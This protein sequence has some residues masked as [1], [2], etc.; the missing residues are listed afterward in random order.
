[1]FQQA[2]IG[3]GSKPAAFFAV[4]NAGTR[5]QQQR[6]RKP[7]VVLLQTILA[8]ARTCREVAKHAEV[9][10]RPCLV[11]FFIDQA[12]A[13]LPRQRCGSRRLQ[14]AAGGYG[15]ALL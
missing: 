5:K 7:C 3:Y 2:G 12:A 4:V 6:R 14:R 10:T 8:F 1:M 13:V 11:S 15:G 9:S